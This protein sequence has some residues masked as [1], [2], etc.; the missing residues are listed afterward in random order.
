MSDFAVLEEQLGYT[1][2]DR[3]VLVNALTHTSFANEH[4]RKDSHLKSN[5]RIE[6]VGDAVLGLVVAEYI[7]Q[8]YPAMP[9]GRMSKLRASVVCEASLAKLAIMLNLD[10]HIKLG[11]G[12]EQSGGRKKAS[13][14]AD[15]FE[16]VFGAIFIDGGFDAVKKVLLPLIV[17]EIIAKSDNVVL[18]DYKSRLQELLGK[19]HIRAE[20]VIIDVKGPDHNRVFTARVNIENGVS[21]EGSGRSKKEAEQA[22]AKTALG[23]M[24]SQ[25]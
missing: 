3:A 7:Y 25:E 22:A 4:F 13:L 16:S 23:L 24:D 20:Y 19:N 8:N 1:F 18:S 12:E 6:F 14:L 21:A 9:E 10:Q 2:S 11:A 5:E 15:L 17:P